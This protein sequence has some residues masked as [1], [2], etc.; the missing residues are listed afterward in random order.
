[1]KSYNVF[2]ISSKPFLPD[3]LSGLLWEL[4][5]TGVTENDDVVIAFATEGSPVNEEMIKGLLNK[6]V[7][8][9]VIEEFSVT[10]E[11]LEEKNWN[12]LWEKSR[13]VIRISERIVIKPTFKEYD[14]KENEI[15]ITL[16][17]KMSFGTGEHESTKLALRLME[18]YVKGNE[19]VLDVGSGTGILSIASI[20]LGTAHAVAVDNDPWCY[21]N[22]TENCA[23]NDV[24]GRIKVIEGEISIIPEEDFDLVLANIQKNILLSISE[25]IKA[26]L[27]KNGIIILSGLLLKDE[28]EII[29]HYQLIGFKFKEKKVM[30]DWI[31]IVFEKKLII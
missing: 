14:S 1:M 22:G 3:I 31:A 15:V 19:K 2:K 6:L 11:I 9:N 23:L 8:Q 7:A 26:K 16:D 5:I 17:P 25:K 28:T 13:E 20:K 29:N 30:D 21:Q 10:R 4:E 24:A 18:K 27:K 12:E